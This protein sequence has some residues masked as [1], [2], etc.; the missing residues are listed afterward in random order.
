M[1]KSTKPRKAYKPMPARMPI[2]YGLAPEVKTELAIEP[3]ITISIFTSGHGNEE[4]AYTL[5]G[6][7]LIGYELAKNDTDRQTLL[8]GSDAMRRVLT[9]GS[10]GKWGFSG[11]DLKDVTAAVTLSDEFQA[12]AT[13]REMRKA[14]QAV[15]AHHTEAP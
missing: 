7:I 3:L 15:W 11:D 8:R 4:L 10:Y 13:R 2:I 6:S 5:I 12:V 9:R 1:G 14:L